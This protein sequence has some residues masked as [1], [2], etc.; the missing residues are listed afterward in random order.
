MYPIGYSILSFFQ[1]A[2]YDLIITI[3][4]VVIADLAVAIFWARKGKP[5]ITIT[6]ATSG[7]NMGFDVSV[8]GH[9]VKSARP[10]CNN[11]SYPWKEDETE[12]NSK[13]LIV[14]D[15]PS[16]F[17]PFQANIEPVDDVSKCEKSVVKGKQESG[18][19]VL[20]TVKEIKTEKIVY[21]DAISIPT[22]AGGLY[23]FALASSPWFFDVSI[24]IIGEGIEEV[25]DYSLQIRFTNLAI[26]TIEEGKPLKDVMCRFVF[27]KKEKSIF[28]RVRRKLI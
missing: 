11:I 3:I 12:S 1:S 21:S 16:S 22:D 2:T 8:K 14:G 24:R 26:P 17:F 25:R 9:S 4:G 27:A 6:S 10:R 15:D 5:K 13:D 7:N 19:G 18:K 20:V 23:V 28:G